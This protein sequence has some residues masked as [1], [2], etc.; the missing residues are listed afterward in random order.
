MKSSIQKKEMC[1]LTCLFLLLAI[2]IV[3]ISLP[4]LTVH[5]AKTGHNSFKSPQEAVKAL[6]E[7]LRA[8]DTK[9]L[10][11]IFGP[12]AKDILSTGDPVQDKAGKEA[13]L[14]A[15]D[16]KNVLVMESNAKAVLQ[17]GTDDWP[18]P[19]PIVK[20]SKKWFFDAR[21]GRE[22]IVNRR[23]GKNELATIQTCLAYVDAQREYAA[24][25]KDGDGLLEYAQKFVSSPGKKDGLYWNAGPGEEESPFGALFAQASKEGYKRGDKPVPYHGYY[26]K[27]LTAQGNNVPGGSLDYIV[28]GRMIGGFA[29]VAYPARYGVSGI[30]TFLVNNNDIVYQKNLGKNTTKLAETMK[31]FNPDK[32]WKRVE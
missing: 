16:A 2:A 24:G 15:Y 17:I 23:I 31:T 26:F 18:F 12:D 22:E 25:D 10:Y 1:L 5:A 27:I 32:S 3:A 20:K 7:A 14:A 19:V 30:M 6:I 21:K 11:A 9:A 29:M 4:P 8:D 13:F 28:R